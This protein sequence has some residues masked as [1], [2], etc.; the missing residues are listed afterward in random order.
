MCTVL[1]N[2]TKVYCANAGDSRAIKVE[3]APSDQGSLNRKSKEYQSITYLVD[4]KIIPTALN[5]DHKPELP[6]EAARIL[7]KHGRIDT[8]HD[9]DG[10]AIGP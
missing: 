8:F 6:D 1:F 10:S 9:Y 4:V 7:A 3:V 2:G 5:R